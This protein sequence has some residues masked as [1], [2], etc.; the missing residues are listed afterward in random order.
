MSRLSPMPLLILSLA[1]VLLQQPLN[2]RPQAQQGA[3]PFD[4]TTKL[5][6]STG[7]VVGQVKSALEMYRRAVFNGPDPDVLDAS[8][9]LRLQCHSLDSAA[10]FAARRVCR[11]CTQPNVQSALDRYR[12][13]MPE[14]ASVGSR[15]AARLA[16]L[17]RKPAPEAARQL[18]H[19]VRVVG[20]AIVTGLI[21]YER[22]LE[23][24]RD[25]AGWA[26]ARTNTAPRRAPRP[27]GG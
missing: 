1:G 11:R 22:R 7:K 21:P 13:I 3:P 10:V 24:L 26:P 17:L 16:L 12:E 15:C 23:A 25:V 4:S 8:T 27:G 20:N 5:V 2:A 14:V 19:D 9:S 18:R 6:S